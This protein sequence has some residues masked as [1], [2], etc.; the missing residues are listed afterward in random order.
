MITRK[1]SNGSD[2]LVGTAESDRLFGLGGDD[3]LS[4]GPGND[5]LDGGAGNDTAS[6]ADAPGR[7]SAGF[8]YGIGVDLGRGTAT[9]LRPGY[10]PASALQHDTLLGIENVI[11]SPFIDHL[12]GSAD[13]NCLWG[14]R[15][16]DWLEGGA[17]NDT[18][19]G[20]LGAD[21]AYGDEGDDL[22]H[23]EEGD[24]F[25]YGGPG[26]DRLHGGPGDDWLTGDAG[27][28][29]LDGGAG[30]DRLYGGA[31]GPDGRDRLVGGTGHDIADYSGSA[32]AVRVDLGRGIA[33]ARGETDRLDGIE[34]VQGSDEADIIRGDGRANT[35]DGGA[36][37]DRV[38]GGA[39]DDRIAD[40]SRERPA[41]RNLLDGGAGDDRV[42]GGDGSDHI[43]GGTGADRLSGGTREALVGPGDQDRIE[44]G[45]DGAC[46]TVLFELF[47]GRPFVGS[48]GVDRLVGFDGRKDMLS[49]FVGQERSGTEG[50]VVDVGSFLDSDDN[51][52]VDAA[53]REVFARGRDL[54]LDIGAVWERAVGRSLPGG[55]EPQEVVLEGMAGRGFAVGL[56]DSQLDSHAD[57]YTLLREPGDFL[58]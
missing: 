14:E 32:A 33:T 19:Y 46:D 26:D 18:L 50:L 44:L 35:L 57:G 11:G 6:W 40:G 31:M 38:F 42:T 55:T 10:E 16:G 39:G 20:G 23:G 56:I 58:L 3:W 24:D 51:G 21:N 7:G 29:L 5:R 9:A 15:G 17:G 36:G 52:I 4:G 1:G 41:E 48:F 47:D 27:D 13:A 22:V 45:A 12:V 54:V 34:G 49:F 37:D 25:L 8:L 53:D 28:D 2:R 43:L 30:D